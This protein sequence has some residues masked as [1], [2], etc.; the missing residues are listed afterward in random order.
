[1]KGGAAR[2]RMNLGPHPYQ[3]NAGNRCD[4]RHSCRSRPT[5]EPKVMCSDRV[6]LCALILRLASTVGLG[7]SGPTL[8]AAP[9]R[10]GHHWMHG[11]VH[12]ARV[13]GRRGPGR[14]LEVTDAS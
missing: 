5:V 13:Q 11:P 3:Q 9:I 8:L 1:M 10:S 2:V 12:L 7:L 14:P 6:Q 4:R